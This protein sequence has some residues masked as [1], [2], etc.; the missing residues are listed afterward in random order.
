MKLVYALVILIVAAVAAFLVHAIQQAREAARESTCQGRMNQLELALRMYE[1]KEGHLPPAYVLGPDGKPWHSW[2]VLLLPY[3]EGDDVYRRYR[4]DEPWN[5]PNISKLAEDL[6]ASRFQCPSGS[7]FGRT[8]NTNYV[9]VVGEG[10]AFPGESTTKFADFKD[11][12]ENT[13]LLV[14]VENSTIHWMEPRDLQFDSLVVA[15]SSP[16]AP[17]VSS[18][19]PRGPGVVFADE[20]TAY[21]LRQ[22][23]AAKTLRALLT[24]AGGEAVTRESLLEPGGGLD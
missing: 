12:V 10:T 7:D 22:P 3:M 16:D 24:I 14:E 11:G 13:I 15:A 18:P 6:D 1:S 23:L 2:R 19:H 5:G 17:A 9:V 20:I 8:N 4:F 21:R